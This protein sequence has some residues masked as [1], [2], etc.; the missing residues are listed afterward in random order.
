M[1]FAEH[2]Y[3][4]LGYSKMTHLVATSM[5]N[6]GLSAHHWKLFLHLLSSNSGAIRHVYLHAHFQLMNLS[7]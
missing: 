6:R 4:L 5:E 7:L 3:H 2:L 1:S